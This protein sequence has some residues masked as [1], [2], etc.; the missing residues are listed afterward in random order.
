MT[1][2]KLVRCKI[3]SKKALKNPFR[4]RRSKIFYFSE[5]EETAIRSVIKLNVVTPISSTIWKDVAGYT[6]R[7]V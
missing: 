6:I 5:V 4:Q 3:F 7:M 1:F 2:W